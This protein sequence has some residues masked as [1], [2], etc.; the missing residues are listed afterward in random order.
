MHTK[1]E[2]AVDLKVSR[3]E[4]GLSNKDV[5][6]LLDIDPARVSRLETG[7]SKPTVGE[8]CALSLIYGKEIGGMLRCAVSTVATHLQTRISNVPDEPENWERKRDKR[9][10]TLQ[11]LYQRLE[12][13]TPT[14][15]ED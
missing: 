14:N 4:S 5:A 7:T 3:R 2:V 15:H 11:H 8:V 6:W 12:D 9:L 1:K 13:L 10:L